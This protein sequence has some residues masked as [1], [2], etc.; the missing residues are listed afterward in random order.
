MYKICLITFLL[1]CQFANG[2]KTVAFKFVPQENRIYSSENMYSIKSV[3]NVARSTEL[4]AELYEQGIFS[5]VTIEGISAWKSSTETKNRV[6]DSIAY[7]ARYFDYSAS[8]TINGETSEVDNPHYDSYVYGFYD[9]QDFQNIIK[10]DSIV[11]KK[12]SI[13][14]KEALKN[15]IRQQDIIYQKSPIKVGD[16]FEKSSTMTSAAIGI[17][18]IEFNIKS[19]YKLN[20]INNGIAYF[21]ITVSLELSNS[22]DSIEISPTSSGH[23]KLE[24]DIEN[25][26]TRRKITC[27]HIVAKTTKDGLRFSTTI[28]TKSSELT[29]L[30]NNFK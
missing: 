4:S 22:E 11:N 10:V 24:F 16:F 17:G 28:L 30:I 18:A 3:V 12:L 26:F 21:D 5:P 13:Q 2:Q 20:S 23:G 25:Q 19:K 29:S 27:Y 14:E 15:Q 6:N 8:Q 7:I 1:F 9:T